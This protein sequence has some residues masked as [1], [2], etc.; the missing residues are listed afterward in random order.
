MPLEPKRFQAVTVTAAVEALTTGSRR[1]LLADEVGLGKTVVAREVI[2]RLAQRHPDRPFR[3]F[4]FGSGRTV[5]AQNAP[6]LVPSS[7]GVRSLTSELCDASRPS[8]I[9][10]EKTPKAQVQI[11]QFTPETAVPRVLGRGRSGVAIE[12]ALLRVL[13]A[14]ALRWRLPRGAEIRAGFQG[15]ASEKSFRASVRGALRQYRAGNLM[16]GFAL[17][18][19][20]R[21]ATRAVFGVGA[22]EQLP[23]R[24]AQALDDPRRFV[25]TLRLALTRAALSCLPPDLIIF[26]EFHRYRDRVFALP[27]EKEEDVFLGLLPRDV[28][29]AILLLSATPFHQAQVASRGNEARA[30]ADDFHRLVGFLHGSGQSGVA[31]YDECRRLFAEFE[32]ALAGKRPGATEIAKVRRKLQEEL[33]RPRM[34]RMERAAFRPMKED[35]AQI[36]KSDGLPAEKDL[37]LF[38]RFSAGLHKKDRSTAIAYWRSVP[39][40]HQF[41]GNEYVAWRFAC[42]QKSRTCVFESC[43]APFLPNSWLCLGCR[44]PCHGG[45]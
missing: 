11:F 5:T 28:R 37:E 14:K 45:N 35:S 22:S 1:F 3:V 24:F 19:A 34:A 4:Y 13:V 25:A 38:V 21:D 33:L 7:S 41:L 42:V 6:R 16:R 12:R 18:D 9:A 26:D 32:R 23:Q 30:D 17:A 29:P 36:P 8:L 31:A 39:Y 2:A 15:A 27:L 10:L 20:F 43:C 40:P 44:R